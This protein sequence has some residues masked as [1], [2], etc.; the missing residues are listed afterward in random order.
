MN[1]SSFLALFFIFFTFS[2]GQD[3]TLDFINKHETNKEYL[4][5]D[6]VSDK[7]A[8][9]ADA[10]YYYA[11]QDVP[12]GVLITNK[13]FW[14]TLDDYAEILSDPEGDPKD[15]E[16]PDTNETKDLSAPDEVPNKNFFSVSLAS[17][18]YGIVT[19]AGNFEE[20]TFATIKAIPEP[21]YLFNQWISD[22]FGSQIDN[23]KVVEVI[24]NVSFTANFSQDTNDNDND[25]LTNYQE[26]IVYKTDSN[27]S[28]TD[29]DGMKDGY[30]VSKGFDPNVFNIFYLLNISSSFG[31]NVSGGGHFQPQSSTT[32]EAIPDP[33]FVFSGWSGDTSGNAN[34][35]FIFLDS[36]KSILANFEQD[37]NDD[38]NDGLTNYEEIVIHS[39][40]HNNADTDNDGIFDKDEI[41]NGFDPRVYTSFTLSLAPAPEGQLIG[42]GQYQPLTYHSIEANPHLGFTFSHW[43]GDISGT[44]NPLIIFLDSDKSISANFAADSSDP[45]QDGLTTYEEVFLY[46]T[47]FNDFDS[48]KD[49]IP[50]GKEIQIG[51]DPNTHEK[52]PAKIEIY[53]NYF[54]FKQSSESRND[55]TYTKYIV[56]DT[57]LT[58]GTLRIEIEGYSALLPDKLLTAES[59]IDITGHKD[60][61]NSDGIFD[62]FDPEITYS[63]SFTGIEKSTFQFEPSNIWEVKYNTVFSITRKVG[64]SSLDVFFEGFAT[65]S[66]I[67]EISVGDNFSGER[68]LFNFMGGTGTLNYGF[69]SYSTMITRS[70]T[71]ETYSINSSLEKNNA[72]SIT[73]KSLALP[74]VSGT[75]SE[76]D[77]NLERED[78]L[79]HKQFTLG[80]ITYYVRVTD[81]IDYDNDG[82]PNISDPS[83]KAFSSKTEHLGD[84]WYRDDSLGIFFP[85]QN[86]H[87]CYHIELGWIYVP[88]WHDQSTWIYRPDYDAGGIYPDY[89]VSGWF[90]TNND[91]FPYIFSSSESNY[92]RGDWLYLGT[93]GVCYLWGDTWEKGQKE[94]YINHGYDW[95]P[96][97]KINP[98]PLGTNIKNKI[99]EV[100]KNQSIELNIFGDLWGDKLFFIPKEISNLSKVKKLDLG[101][102]NIIDL[103]NLSELNQLEE[104]YLDQNW[105]LEDIS[106]LS[107]LR[108]LKHLS[109]YA[110][111]V[112]DIGAL[113]NLT[114]L[115]TLNL[116]V[117]FVTDISS[118]SNLRN[119]K[120]LSLYDTSVRDI[121]ALANL[122]N[123]E[124][125]DLD[126]ED[127]SPLSNLN[128]LREL[129]VGEEWAKVSNL[130]PLE[131]LQ[132]LE[133][134]NIYIAENSDISPLSKLRNLKSLRVLPSLNETQL[135]WLKV[136]L[137]ETDIS[138]GRF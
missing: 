63:K 91:I 116:S 22:R 88:F 29:E 102:N 111:S 46:N 94:W 17:N 58:S 65:S 33:G 75:K 109:L 24:S 93:G 105:G 138:E 78:N 56:R 84:G 120:H 4:R 49:G 6:L 121:G 27:K 68:T 69:N 44:S 104:L 79:F 18:G 19:G 114:N 5:G 118:L 70:D 132:K 101:A 23:P 74:N 57:G 26:I 15:F 137:P 35:K 42:D 135:N 85:D 106:S 64:Q 73:L 50:D 83:P 126:F 28:D 14:S 72:N 119:L 55:F 92:Q 31:G 122:T 36:N 13:Q 11:I 62:I 32:M 8:D 107:N 16:S 43:S 54:D 59:L 115:E 60:D 21:G 80:E 41:E 136:S 51:S 39:T 53:S 71:S 131:N 95:A 100:E 82:I 76:I 108:N 66:N 99:L 130:T 40:D 48:D 87:W 129:Y 38:D 127:I 2:F 97:S 20:G 123:L 128:N 61:A 86:S 34:P 133:I 25:G 124:T 96:A 81:F 47:K 12:P 90:W 134:L 103:T 125:L 67:P 10:V 9:S 7:A 117:T 77:V 3:S 98:E 45:D 110:T 89:L 112:G 30:E 113:A 1:S 37:L 52:K